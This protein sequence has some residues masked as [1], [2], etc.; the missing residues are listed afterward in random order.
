MGKQHCAR[1]PDD[2]DGYCEMD[3]SLLP[4]FTEDDDEESEHLPRG[5]HLLVPFGGHR[6]RYCRV[7]QLTIS[8][9]PGHAEIGG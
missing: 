7:S 4:Q 6:K 1:N 8:F 5:E 3:P 2:D 9:G